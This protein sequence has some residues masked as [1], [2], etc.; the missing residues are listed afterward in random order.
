M[1]TEAHSLDEWAYLEFIG[2][3]YVELVLSI[4]SNAPLSQTLTAHID[5][6][7]HLAYANKVHSILG[8]KDQ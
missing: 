4:K 6:E 7:E 1:M 5:I 8:R 2:K 3:Q